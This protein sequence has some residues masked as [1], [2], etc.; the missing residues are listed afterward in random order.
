MQKLI[1]CRGLPASGKTT[2][3]REYIAQAVKPT[4]RINQDDLRAMV[5]PVWT[6]EKEKFINVSKH[7]LIEIALRSGFD[8]VC[9]DTNLNPKVF[10]SLVDL[11]KQEGAELEVKDFRDVSI[12]TCLERDSHRTGSAK[13]GPKVIFRMARQ[14]GLI[15]EPRAWDPDRELPNAVIV[16]LDGTLALFGNENPYD[17]AFENDIHNIP[18]IEVLRGLHGRGF[19]ILITSGRSDKY[20]TVTETW[21]KDYVDYSLLLMRDAKDVRHDHT[22]KKEMYENH[23]K[24][25]YNILAVFDDRPQVVRFWRSQGL[26]VF[27]VNQSGLEF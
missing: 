25:K 11:A 2:W 14:Y 17:R 3:A 20:R 6:K 8:V 23:I 16:D 22:V 1:I 27:D 13:V 26:F 15:P 4:K 18:V 19:E 10:D 5:D 9:D 24:G 21:L 12:E 7:T